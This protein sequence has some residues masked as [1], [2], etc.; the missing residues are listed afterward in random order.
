MRCGM[1]QGRLEITVEFC[2]NLAQR[3]YNSVPLQQFHP[4]EGAQKMVSSCSI[5]LPHFFSY[6]HFSPTPCIVNRVHA[7]SPVFREGTQH[8]RD[9]SSMGRIIQETQFPWG[10]MMSYTFRLGTHRLGTHR[11]VIIIDSQ[12]YQT[13]KPE[14]SFFSFVFHFPL[15]NRQIFR[16]KD[17]RISV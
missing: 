6:K 10:G 9:L 3:L 1:V 8:P 13:M 7:K 12:L 4:K 17:L 2:T 14:T 16:L 11:H 15:I 5:D